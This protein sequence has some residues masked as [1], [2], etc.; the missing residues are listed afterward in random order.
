MRPLHGRVPQ[1]RIYVHQV[2]SK[3]RNAL[4]C[5]RQG[6]RILNSAIA[7]EHGEAHTPAALRIV[8][9]T[10]TRGS[11]PVFHRLDHM[12]N[13]V[14]VLRLIGGIS[15][16]DESEVLSSDDPSRRIVPR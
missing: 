9:P 16:I 4:K 1:F 15:L 5:F 2:Y 11:E 3:N 7:R 8:V 13:A 12:T 14:R 10:N 6:Q